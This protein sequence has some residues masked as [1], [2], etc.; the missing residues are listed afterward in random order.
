MLPCH[1]LHVTLF[2]QSL[3]DCEVRYTTFECTSRLLSARLSNGLFHYKRCCTKR[4]SPRSLIVPFHATG[5]FGFCNP[6]F[7][8]LARKEKRSR[9]KAFAW[10]PGAF[11]LGSCTC[12][13][14]A[15]ISSFS[16]AIMNVLYECG[17]AIGYGVKR[18]I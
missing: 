3:F 4:T 7:H 18:R 5:R 9:P 14:L 8:L 10:M 1:A 6:F 12:V 13:L 2:L 15:G 17:N 11:I 16:M